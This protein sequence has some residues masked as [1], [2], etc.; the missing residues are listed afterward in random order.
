[1]AMPTPFIEFGKRFAI[2]GNFANYETGQALAFAGAIRV[3]DGLSLSAG[4]GYGF[5][6]TTVGV[7]GGFNFSW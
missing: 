4:A 2:A 7:R 5:N 3:N 6:K 1:M